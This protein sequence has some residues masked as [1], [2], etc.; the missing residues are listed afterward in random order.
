[1]KHNPDLLLQLSL[2]FA[3]NPV[4]WVVVISQGLGA[5][6]L[7]ERISAQNL[8][9]LTVLDY[10]PLEVLPDV[11]A[12]GDVLVAIL[13]PEAGIYSVPSKVLSYLCAGRS[14]LLAMSPDNLAA[15][16]VVEA[17]AGVV[18]NPDNLSGFV[19]AARNLMERPDLREFYGKNARRYAEMHFDIDQITWQFEEILHKI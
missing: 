12:A 4:G 14:L 19:S 13:E 7:K 9:N 3:G 1:M 15:R 6:W 10:Q 2:A 8:G 5:D 17:Q 16:T 11:L 18:V